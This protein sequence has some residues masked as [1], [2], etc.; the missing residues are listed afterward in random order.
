M[1]RDTPGAT[2]GRGRGTGPARGSGDRRR[3]KEGRVN[4]Q[5]APVAHRDF[6][7]SHLL[8]ALH[9][10]CYSWAE[11]TNTNTSSQNPVALT[12]PQR[13]PSPEVVTSSR[14]RSRTRNLGARC[15]P[16]A[17]VQWSSGS[18]SIPPVSLGRSR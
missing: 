18:E 13:P 15:L 11:S 17:A 6:E 4:E 7:I 5:E 14:L 3:R 16:P 9:V 8:F 2:G 12:R 1:Q 10:S